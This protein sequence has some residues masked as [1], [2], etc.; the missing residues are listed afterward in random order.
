VGFYLWRER[1][2]RLE[3]PTSPALAGS[4]IGSQ[5][6]C[7]TKGV[8][9]SWVYWCGAVRSDHLP[10]LCCPPYSPE[11]E[12]VL[13]QKTGLDGTCRLLD[14][15][16]GPGVLTIRLAQLF[17]RAVG[18]DPDACLPRAAVYCCKVLS[19]RYDGRSGNGD[20]AAGPC[21]IVT[22]FRGMEGQVIFSRPWQCSL[23]ICIR[24]W[25]SDRSCSHSSEV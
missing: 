16:C 11:L 5:R 6:A 21:V 25:V 12:A 8:D 2:A 23:P 13:T 19:W 22:A 3:E 20:D 24:L 7:C 4:G 14:A 9:G 10:R 1:F 15:G 17:E 18:L